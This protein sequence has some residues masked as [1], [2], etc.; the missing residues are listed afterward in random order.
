[1]QAGGAAGLQI[2]RGTFLHPWPEKDELIFV[3]LLHCNLVN[4]NTILRLTRT[5]LIHLAVNA[6]KLTAAIF[7]SDMKRDECNMKN[8]KI[9]D[10]DFTNEPFRL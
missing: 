4:I 1:M 7:T 5:R 3:H 10:S 2:C 6:A 9:H 8:T